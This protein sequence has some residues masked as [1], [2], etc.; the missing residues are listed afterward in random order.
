M[1]VARETFN[2]S[3]RGNAE[4]ID[5]TSEVS[6][7]VTRSGISSGIVTVFVPGATA[8]V[9]TIEFEPGLVEDMDEMFE[10]LIPQGREY[11]HN[12]RWHDGNGHAHVRAALQGPTLTVP[13]N[14]GKLELGIWQQIVLI[15]FDNR[16][17]T[18]EVVCQVIGE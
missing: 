16:S 7:A 3:T 18:R 5:V 17:R 8:S 9:T 4:L 11:H 10:R 14:A 1:A 12:K 13:F 6:A 15:D 2:L